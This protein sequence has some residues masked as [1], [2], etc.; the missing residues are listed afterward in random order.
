[1]ERC[2]NNRCTQAVIQVVRWVPVV[3]ILAVVSWAYYAYVYQ[4]CIRK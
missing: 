4:L 2:L 1:M 3:F